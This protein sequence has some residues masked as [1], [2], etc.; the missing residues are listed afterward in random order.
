MTFTPGVPLP[1]EVVGLPQIN[2][3]LRQ[4]LGCFFFTLVCIDP[5]LLLSSCITS[6]AHTKQCINPPDG[7]YIDLRIFTAVCK[8][9]EIMQVHYSVP[10]EHANQ[11]RASAR[12]FCLFHRPRQTKSY[13]Q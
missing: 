12:S 7:N 10:A 3:G 6:H 13:H 11:F 8:D 5:H 4:S 2:G 1:L 9:N